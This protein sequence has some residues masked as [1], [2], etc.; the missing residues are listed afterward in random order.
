MNNPNFDSQEVLTFR[1]Q[2]MLVND[3]YNGFDTSLNH[4]IAYT[5]ENNK[6]FEAR[7]RLASLFNY[8]KEAITTVRNMIF[9]KPSDL[10]FLENSIFKDIIKTIDFNQNLESFMQNLVVN[11]ARDGYSFI[12]VE[13]QDYSDVYSGADETNKRPYLINVPRLNVKNF[14]VN[15]NGQF[16]V[17]TYNE[18]YAIDDK[19]SQEVK[20][21]Q[22]C[23]LED[24]T[25]EL[26]RDNALYD[27]YQNG[28]GYIPIIKVGRDDISPF[29]D[30]A[31]INRNHLNLKSEQRNYARIAA[32]P[33]PV[34]YMLD[35]GSGEVQTIGVND[36]INFNSPKNEAGFEW[37]ELSGQNN[38]ILESLIKKD[39]EQM[40]KY[41][42]ALVETSVVKTAKEASLINVG[43]ESALNHYASIVEDAINKAFKI[44]G[45]YQGIKNFEADVK[46]NRDFINNMID[47]Q[48]VAQYLGLY[49]QGVISWR[50]LIDILISGETLPPM[51]DKEI[52]SMQ[53]DLIQ[54]GN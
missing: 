19:Y 13:K 35:N 48:M 11:V 7:K 38:S 6:N 32:A 9:R 28:L 5:K 42:F 27:T 52:E 30:L 40:N 14:K 17:F 21:Q 41:L 54:V 20:V 3:F 23:Y 31:V 36:G 44:M 12:V 53:V 47:S 18:T 50:K 1:P 49:T 4:I 22:R 37:V 51:T 25:V 2:L 43:N 26:W 16:T 29:Y 39:E 45:E 24:G 15:Q 33:I 34:T 10:T 8:T 46:I